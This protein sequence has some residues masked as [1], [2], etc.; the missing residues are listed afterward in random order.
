MIAFNGGG[1]GSRVDVPLVSLLY[2]SIP[3]SRRLEVGMVFQSR[4]GKWDREYTFVV[5]RVTDQDAGEGVV[6]YKYDD[7][8][9]HH[10]TTYDKMY[11]FQDWDL[12]VKEA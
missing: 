6:I 4:I 12:L 7:V 2:P 1:C 11:L 8:I 9:K 5:T 10:L 3:E